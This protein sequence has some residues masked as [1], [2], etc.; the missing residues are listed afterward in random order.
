MTAVSTPVDSA[1]EERVRWGAVITFMLVAAGLAWLVT[2]PL[3]FSG[4][5]LAFPG[6]G[7]LLI[8]M[9]FTPTI[10]TIVVTFVFR[11]PAEGRLRFLGMWPL[12]P[13]K[14]VVWFMV[15]GWL[16]PFAV[17]VI[18]TAVSAALG[19]VRL[20]MAGFSGFAEVLEAQL[21]AGTTV[22]PI[23]LL[24]A[25]QLLT[26]PFGALVNCVATA[27]EEIG[28]RGW[29]LPSLRPL[30]TWPALVISGIVWGL[31]HSPVILLGYNF[32]RTDI[33]G[34]LFMVGGC[35][36]WGIALGWLRLRS[37]SVWPAVLAHGMLNAAGALVLLVAAAG[38]SYDLALVGPLGVVAWGVLAVMI[39]VLI[40]TGQFRRQPELAPSRT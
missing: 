7:L 23:G 29:L 38:Q 3:W 15:L 11:A 14:R 35:V 20:D 32:G 4:Q 5:G 30:G 24:V 26:L 27:G 36:A 1:L 28:W 37:A 34:V 6:A 33:T 16:A 22:P 17:V 19:L 12:R 21:P 8:V 13:A 2:S 39:V 9:M 10:A 25:V 31:W 40:A 18:V